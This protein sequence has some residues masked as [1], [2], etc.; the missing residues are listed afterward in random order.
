MECMHGKSTWKWE[1]LGAEDD[2]RGQMEVKKGNCR[3]GKCEGKG[4]CQIVTFGQETKTSLVYHDAIQD[5][6][7]E[8]LGQATVLAS[9]HVMQLSKSPIAL[10]Y[11]WS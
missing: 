3:V 10:S 5:R 8:G 7:L 4:Q 9:A 1:V 6:V 2:S 11:G